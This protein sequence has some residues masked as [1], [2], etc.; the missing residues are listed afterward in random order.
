MVLKMVETMRFDSAWEMLCTSATTLMRSLVDRA[1]VLPAL[2]P[3]ASG[4]AAAASALSFLGARAG[5]VAQKGRFCS[6]AALLFVAAAKDLG[7]AAKTRE[8]V[9]LE[10]MEETM[11]NMV[12]IENAVVVVFNVCTW[13]KPELTELPLHACRPWN[14]SKCARAP[15]IARSRKLAHDRRRH[16]FPFLSSQTPIAQFYQCPMPQRLR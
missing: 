11:W 9:A 12:V 4:T 3:S 7:V 10:R 15:T 6:V 8:R 13:S 14:V 1:C 16:P 5:V 2:S